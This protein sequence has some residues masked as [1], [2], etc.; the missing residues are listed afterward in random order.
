[1]TKQEKI[2]KRRKIL[3]DIDPHCHQCGCLTELP[4]PYQ[5]GVLPDN[6]ATLQHIFEVDSP[7]RRDLLDDT[8][9]FCHKC[10]HED[11]K[12]MRKIYKDEGKNPKVT[13]KS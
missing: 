8:V 2:K 12:I 5:T 11:N 9:L 1:M 7:M 6:T 3:W 10:N 4:K 13:R